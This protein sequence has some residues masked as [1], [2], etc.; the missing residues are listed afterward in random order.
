M[1]SLDA[2]PGELYSAGMRAI[3]LTLAISVTGCSFAF[4][5]GPPAD[6]RQLPAFSCSESRVVPVLDTIWTAL[7]TTNL[8][9]AAVSSDK[10]WNDLYGGNAPLS[11]GAAIPLYAV[12]V[13]LGAAGMYYGY[14][15]TS[16]CRE[17]KAEAAGRAMQPMPNGAAPGTWPPPGAAPAPVAP[18]PA[19][20]PAPAAP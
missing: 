4:V 16:E 6:H 1:T 14:T 13:A 15:R 7:Q 2:T 8:I 10:S 17:A 19:A 11:R 9:T 5:S 18:P 3:A 12:F 20:E